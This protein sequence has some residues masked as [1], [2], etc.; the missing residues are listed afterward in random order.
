ML[1][2]ASIVNYCSKWCLGGLIIK[3]QQLPQCQSVDKGIINAFIKADG[4][5]GI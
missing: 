1:A 2:D 5:G 4:F 3:K